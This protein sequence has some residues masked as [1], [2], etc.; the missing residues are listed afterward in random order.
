MDSARRFGDP[1]VLTTVYSGVTIIYV[2]LHI[3]YSSSVC[4]SP[5]TYKLY[6]EKCFFT[7]VSLS[8]RTVPGTRDLLSSYLLVTWNTDTRAQ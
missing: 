6:G 2:V 1:K 7:D 4:A 8:S 3:L 5:I